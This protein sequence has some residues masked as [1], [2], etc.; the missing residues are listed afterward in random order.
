V[1]RIRFAVREAALGS[2]LIAA[3][4]KGV[5]A[6]ALGDDP[7]RLVRDLYD[8]F[9]RATPVAGGD[10]SF[11]R[12]VADVVD[13]VE[14]PTREHSVP[15]DLRGTAFQRR[16][17]RALRAIPAGSTATYTDIARRIGAPE[18]ARAVG[19]AC[20]SNAIAVLVPCHR[21]VRADGSLARYRWG[22][23]RKRALLAREATLVGTAGAG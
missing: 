16:V 3:T 11:A 20:A 6:V 17:W 13:C 22:V 18:A 7:A 2:M 4:D 10:R 8:R 5:C 9:P 21:A 1:A 23:R 14:A 15:L 19:R 12:L